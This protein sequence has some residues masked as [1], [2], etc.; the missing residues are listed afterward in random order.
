MKIMIFE[1]DDED[2]LGNDYK[3]WWLIIIVGDDGGG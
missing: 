3:W 2:G 1:G